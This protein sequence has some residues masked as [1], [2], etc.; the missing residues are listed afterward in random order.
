LKIISGLGPSGRTPGLLLLLVCAVALLAA[1]GELPGRRMLPV[2]GQLAD[3]L[4][5]LSS[6]ALLPLLLQVFHVYA[7]FR[8]LIK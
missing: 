5:L 3:N 8:A 6:L 2:W 7:H 4:E 1:S